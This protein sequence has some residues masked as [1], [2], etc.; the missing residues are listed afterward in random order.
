[1]KVPSATGFLPL[2]PQAG[3]TAKNSGGSSAAKDQRDPRLLEAARMYEKQFLREMVKAMRSTVMESDFVEHSQGEKIFREQLDDQY[4]DQWG[5]TGGVGLADLIYQNIEER[6]GSSVK[7]PPRKNFKLGPMPIGPQT[8]RATAINPT[9]EG[10][11]IKFRATSK[12]PNQGIGSK[13]PNQGIDSKEPVTSPMGEGTLLAHGS[14]NESERWA[15]IAHP[16][17][18]VSELKFKGDLNPELISN[19]EI[20][21]DTILGWIRPNTEFKLSLGPIKDSSATSL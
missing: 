7:L 8:G 17:G 13:E 4:V 18:L 16:N 14:I 19:N 3:T 1:L 5:S 12:E 9:S 15:K 2:E 20:K 11:E 6:F 21:T 10:L